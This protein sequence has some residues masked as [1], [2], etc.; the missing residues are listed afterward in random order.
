MDKREFI[1]DIA[2]GLILNSKTMYAQN[3]VPLL[4]ASC[5]KT[6]VGNEYKG[7]RGIYKLLDSIYYRLENAGKDDDAES[8]AKAFK[9]A[10]GRY[11][12]EK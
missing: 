2:R 12:Y 1:L 5:Y 4:N 10:N 7:G 3:L 8:I 11:A 6:D 9:N